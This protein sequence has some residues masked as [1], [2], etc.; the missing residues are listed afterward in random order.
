MRHAC[1]SWKKILPRDFPVL[2]FKVRCQT[3][4][5]EPREVPSTRRIC[6]GINEWTGEKENNRSDG[7]IRLTSNS[8]CDFALLLSESALRAIWFVSSQKWTQ[9]CTCLLHRIPTRKKLK[10]YC[11]D[12][13]REFPPLEF[14]LPQ[15]VHEIDSPAFQ[16]RLR[17]FK[18]YTLYIWIKERNHNNETRNAQSKQALQQRKPYQITNGRYKL[19]VVMLT[20]LVWSDCCYCLTDISMSLFCFAGLGRLEHETELVI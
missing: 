6:T 1:G 3:P 14:L 12:K 5:K 18:Y 8:F 2:S 16:F 20:A 15:F 10:H 7:L 17:Y 13:P 4:P 11:S 19:A 9:K